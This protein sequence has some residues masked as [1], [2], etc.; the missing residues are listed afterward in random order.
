MILLDAFSSDSIPLHLLTQEAMSLYLSKLKPDGVIV[1][2]IS[3]RY[4]ELKPMLG[5]AAANNRLVCGSDL[6]TS[7]KKSRKTASAS[8]S[9]W[10]WPGRN[11]LGALAKND[12]W[13]Q[14]PTAKTR[15]WTDDYSNILSVLNW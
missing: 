13:T 2:Q 12:R 11:D 14:V 7:A 15:V 9:T 3:N 8:R 6:A 1:I 5:Q 10:S 4:L